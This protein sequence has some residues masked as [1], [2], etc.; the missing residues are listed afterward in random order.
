VD[1]KEPYQP[2]QLLKHGP[3]LDITGQ[4]SGAKPN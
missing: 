1:G 2:P 3:L 4:A